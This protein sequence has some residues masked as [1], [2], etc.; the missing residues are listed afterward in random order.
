MGISLVVLAKEK[1]DLEI[2]LRKM[3]DVSSHDD[4][5]KRLVGVNDKGNWWQ[6]STS[7]VIREGESSPMMP[8]CHHKV[9]GIG[10]KGL[11]LD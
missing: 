10:D 6:N 4:M 1:M 2:F 9:T 3:L 7:L 11:N 5:W 8:T